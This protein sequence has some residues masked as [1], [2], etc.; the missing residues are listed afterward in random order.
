MAKKKNDLEGT[1]NLPRE[2]FMINDPEG[3]VRLSGMYM[4]IKFSDEEEELQYRING[5]EL[6]KKFRK[7]Q[8]KIVPCKGVRFY[9][10]ELVVAGKKVMEIELNRPGKDNFKAVVD[11]EEF[12][13]V[14]YDFD[15]A[16]VYGYW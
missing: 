5:P 9:Y 7:F 14:L 6:I 8:R 12:R 11:Y 16:K 3:F 15:T 13:Q 1:V 4:W 10:N 2:L